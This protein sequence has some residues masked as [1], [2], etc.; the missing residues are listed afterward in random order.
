M[1]HPEVTL[2]KF[3]KSDNGNC[4][5][6][7]QDVNKSPLNTFSNLLLGKGDKGKKKE[8]SKGAKKGRREKR[9]EIKEERKKGK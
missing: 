4:K 9:K 1:I 8:R 2:T 5:T 6:T 7:Y 3:D